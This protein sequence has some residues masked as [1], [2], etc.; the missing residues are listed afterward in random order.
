MIEFG[1]SLSLLSLS[2]WLA[3]FAG[4]GFRSV[5]DVGTLFL[6]VVVVVMC[7]Y[8]FGLQFYGLW[9]VR[10]EN[11]LNPMHLIKF[12]VVDLIGRLKFIRQS[13][14]FYMSSMYLFL[15]A[16]AT[17]KNKRKK[18]QLLHSM[19]AHSFKNGAKMLRTVVAEG[20]IHIKIVIVLS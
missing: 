14:V 17:M 4:S 19:Q 8:L 1:R 6:F 20:Q 10:R 18:L 13:A 5:A 2:L 11:R 9:L 16:S 7:M 3:L 12:A 15:I